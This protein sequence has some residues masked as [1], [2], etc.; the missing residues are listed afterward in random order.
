MTLLNTDGSIQYT[1]K[2]ETPDETIFAGLATNRPGETSVSV[3]LFDILAPHLRQTMPEIFA[4][5]T[6]DIAVLL[7]SNFARRFIL[8]PSGG[9]AQNID[10]RANYSYGKGSPTLDSEPV[11]LELPIGAP[12]P[13]SV[14]YAPA[15]NVLLKRSA[16]TIRTLSNAAACAINVAFDTTDDVS[17]GNVLRIQYPSGTNGV[18]GN[19]Y[20]PSWTMRSRCRDEYVLY[21]VNAFGGID[22]LWLRGICRRTDA[23]EREEAGVYRLMGD[24]TLPDARISRI[25]SAVTWELNTGWLTDAQS[26]VFSRNV[27]G[28]PCAYLLKLGTDAGGWPV[29]VIDASMQ[30]GRT[31]ESN[32][33]T[34]VNYTLNVQLLQDRPRL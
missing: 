19:V 33:R 21:Y 25:D 3:E 7:A 28:T 30:H 9:S 29:K 12:L 27:P 14:R 16:T 4:V 15:G 31:T 20:G 1:V 17:D 24:N 8:T 32:G 6:D 13:G 5:Y 34:P 26:R 22:A 23:F 11:F 10:V 2:T 18:S